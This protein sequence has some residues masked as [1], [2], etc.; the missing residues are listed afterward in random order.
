MNKKE[1]QQKFEA[2][3]FMHEDIEK[4]PCPYKDRFCNTCE[5]N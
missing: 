2:E 1:L 3:C 4:C 5:V